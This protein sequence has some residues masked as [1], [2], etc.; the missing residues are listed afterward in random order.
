MTEKHG[1]RKLSIIDN[2][3]DNNEVSSQDSR[4]TKDCPS[5]RYP[6]SLLRPP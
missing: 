4:L 6:D 1:Q 2:V 5:R 3:L